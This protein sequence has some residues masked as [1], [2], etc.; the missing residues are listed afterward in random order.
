M[1]IQNGTNNKCSW[2]ISYELINNHILELI[3]DD[4]NNYRLLKS[5]YCLDFNSVKKLQYLTFKIICFT[6][7]ESIE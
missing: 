3:P 1:L 2:R 4:K 6:V 5:R 7:N